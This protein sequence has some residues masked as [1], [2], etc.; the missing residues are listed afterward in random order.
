MTWF[1]K[2]KDWLLRREHDRVVSELQRANVQLDDMARTLR[3]IADKK[4]PLKRL[5]KDMQEDGEE[6]K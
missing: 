4:D 5:L 6:R 2:M 1:S 3:E